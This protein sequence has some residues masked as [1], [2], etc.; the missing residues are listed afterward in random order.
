MARDSGRPSRLKAEEHRAAL[1]DAA[2]PLYAAD[3]YAGVRVRDIVD[4]AGVSLTTFYKHFDDREACLKACFEHVRDE[5]VGALAAAV[6]AGEDP[7]VRTRAILDALFAYL[8]DNPD[9]ARMILLETIGGSRE[10]VDELWTMMHGFGTFV[11]E[12]NHMSVS[13]GAARRILVGDHALFVAGGV[14]WVITGHIRN[15]TLTQ[16]RNDDATLSMVVD[17]LFA[18][19]DQIME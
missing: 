18:A 14:Y 6:V 11:R 1:I 7:R 15:G 8:D 2:I 5:L 3:T 13:E 4:A 17:A 9:K 10:T 16:L 19:R 12:L